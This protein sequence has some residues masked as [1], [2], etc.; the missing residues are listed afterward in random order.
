MTNYTIDNSDNGDFSRSITWQ[1]DNAPNICGIILDLFKNA[2]DG[3]TKNFW[4]SFIQNFLNIDTANAAG[5]S[6][7]GKRLGV[8]R[9]GGIGDSLYRRMIKAKFILLRSNASIQDFQLYV[10][11]IFGVKNSVSVH[12]NLD[13]SITYD[14][15]ET[16]VDDDD[17]SSQEFAI[18]A[19][20]N[21]DVVAIFPSGVRDGSKP[22]VV[23]G[24]AGQEGGVMGYETGN[25]NNSNFFA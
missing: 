9:P 22:G 1:F 5:L 2:Y 25:I 19:F 11:S 3:T 8:K 14:F 10:D 23:F 24:L 4:N 17:V 12:D 7:W 18:L 20:S 13:M 21:Y 6:A 15:P 16:F